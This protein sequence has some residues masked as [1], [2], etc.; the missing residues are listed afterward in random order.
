MPDPSAPPATRAVT[1]ARLA[2]SVVC[3]HGG[4]VG[5]EAL[6]VGR[7]RGRVVS[8]CRPGREQEHDP[9]IVQAMNGMALAGLER[10]QRSRVAC[11]R[12]IGS[13]DR[14]SAGDH[15][16]DRAFAHTVI[17]EGLAAEKVEDDDPAFRR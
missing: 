2:G 6:I 1:A 12:F 17:R 3:G 5:R 9:R 10:H 13:L 14:D 15:F 8:D 7:L 16:D 4:R 11:H